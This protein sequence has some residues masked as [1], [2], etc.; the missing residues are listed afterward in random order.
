M[1][2]C[3]W[4]RDRAL[5]GWRFTAHEGRLRYMAPSAVE[6]DAHRA[7][8][9]ARRDEILEILSRDP[10]DLS[11]APLSYG[12]R[13]LWFLWL[14]APE[15]QAYHVSL[16]LQID[17]G[18]DE[19]VWRLAAEALVSRHEMLRTRFLRHGDE[20]VQQ[21]LAKVAIDWR[22]DRAAGRSDASLQAAMSAAHAQP[23]DLLA[24]PPVRFQWFDGDG[25]AILL[26]TMHHIVCDAWSLE[27]MR[28][29]LAENA[30]AFS[31]GKTG[32]TKGPAHTYV[33]FVHW[34]RALLAS[35]AGAAL[36]TFWRDRLAEPRPPVD[37]P[38][39]RPR[40]AVQTYQGDS[41]AVDIPAALADRGRELAASVGTT[42]HM[43]LLTSFLAVL[44]RWTRQRDL[45]IGIP[46]VARSQPEFG[47]IVGYFVEPIVLRVGLEDRASFA[48]LLA[49]VTRRHREAL[50]HAE[51]PFALLVE[52]LRVERDP[53][54]SPVF[55]V[56]FNFLSRR[57]AAHDAPE[58]GP[59]PAIG[60]LPQAD[61]KFDVTLTVEETERGDIRAALGYN[62]AL[63][64]RATIGMIAAAL[65]ALLE[66]ACQRPDE[67]VDA[68]SLQPVGPPRPALVGRSTPRDTL[69]PVHEAVARHAVTQPAQPAVVAADGALTYAELLDRADRLAASL[70]AR[71][72]GPNVPVG[73]CTPRGT[74]FAVGLL[75][76]LRAGSA[77]LPIEPSV[78]AGLRRAMLEQAG[79]PFAVDEHDIERLIASA[80]G[81]ARL[82]SASLDNLAYV[83]FTSGST[84]VPK[85]V[86]VTHLALANYVTS[87]VDDLALA[88]GQYGFVSTVA[89][90]LGHTV[91]FPSLV[92][93][94]TLHI[95]SAGEVG[96]RAAFVDWL[97]RQKIDY[98][99]IVPSH[100]AAL[101]GE[102]PP[103]LP[104]RALILGGE[105][106]STSM[107]S[108]WQAAGP[109]CRIFNH[110]G[111]TETTVGVLTFAVPPQMPPGAE[112]L[113][114]D[115][116]VANAAVWVLDANGHP[117]PP[118]IPGE[119]VV[120]GACVARGYL[121][122]PDL[123]AARFKAA[124]D[125]SR[126]YRTGDLARQ[127]ANGRLR[128]LGRV[129]RQVKI[130]GYRVE[131]GH[132]EHV[133]ADCPEVAQAV[134][135]PDA[136]PAATSLTA[137]V[138]L[139]SPSPS[140]GFES[141]LREWLSSRV[142]AYLVPDR[143]VAL[144]EIPLTSN[145]KIDDRALE[146]HADKEPRARARRT[147]ARDLVELR[148][149]R[150]WRSVLGVADVRPTDDFFRLGGHSLL[151]VRLGSAIFDEF[152]V[153]LPL[154]SF[155]THRTLERLAAL[156][157]A[158]SRPA[159]ELLI[160]LQPGT[161]RPALVCFP[162]AGGSL[163]YFQDLLSAIGPD[164]PVWG[165]QAP[166]LLDVPDAPVDVTGLASVYANAVR[167][168]FGSDTPPGLAGHSFGAMLAFEVARRLEAEGVQI[169][170]VGIIDN[171]APGLDNEGAST[172]DRDWLLHIATRI[173]RMHGVDLD[174]E[175]AQQSQGR[176]H[177]P[178]WLMD[179]LTAAGIL[180]AG[181]RQEYFARW[182]EL[183]RSNA[184]AA[185]EY[186]PSGR[187]GFPLTV[188]R[189][190]QI[191]PRL[192]RPTSNDA[193]LGWSAATS[194][195]VTVV[196]VPG[197]HITMLKDPNVRVLA[198]HLRSAVAT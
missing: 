25:T 93:G 1:T 10:D 197:S 15:S 68:L 53:S 99:K 109:D 185:A 6:G 66:D 115:R 147:M 57:A 72:A 30:R 125:G 80:P 120:A 27:L 43:V 146:A 153:H 26:I 85:A 12:Q 124:P 163:L 8:L 56:T 88:A 7:E 73:L 132:V 149:C 158:E 33:D 34:Q 180:P 193:S 198:H 71:G 121:G 9:G 89:A 196:D 70:V 28:R 24:A 76:I 188:F 54:R 141:R 144:P 140:A 90:D 105:S 170:F 64:E 130:R 189:A 102:A 138:V 84:G 5:E 4:A 133:L 145:G 171:P 63:F 182:V 167:T 116:A 174:L 101:V 126:A 135:R 97:V 187:A 23:F 166:G 95:A 142:P 159:M 137:Y 75:G 2:T 176:H 13:A 195:P 119:I 38:T 104:R 36:W 50:A 168:T 129:D 60:D 186:R 58:D 136:V 169:P 122:D 65:R 117:V 79:A 31:R 154:A 11:V 51:F 175:H 47:D 52:R 162:G 111:P 152:G 113:P 127:D 39:D 108:R 194:G 191:D 181:A 92:E 98:L 44:Y 46:A 161:R 62:V 37:L 184:R 83:I 165:A 134:V 96:N 86:G 155:F 103:V 151:A 172:D 45:T 173:E 21:A 82:P 100:F 177:D 139:A 35:P 106:S 157:S 77:Y 17:R 61:G 19:A 128:I 29:E 18:V 41:V 40:P 94:G 42:L 78:D 131:P 110:Y 74:S 16:P 22:R 179:R 190:A 160:P 32:R 81:A 107:V 112:T 178:A 55:D 148:L 118:G 3:D 114:L 20:P 59:A 14:L 123:T 156:V 87:I 192:G 164:L 183:Y 150:L 49:E 48:G 69:R 67:A 143:F 91:L